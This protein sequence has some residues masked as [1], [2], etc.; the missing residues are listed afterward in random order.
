MF[1]R[2]LVWTKRIFTPFALG[3]LLYATWQSRA[4]LVMLFTTAQRQN[5]II[6]LPLLML[7]HLI[8]PLA[9][10]VGLKSLGISVP[11]HFTLSTHIHRLPA[12]Y[13]PGGIWHSVGRMMDFHAYGIHPTQLTIFFVLENILSISVSFILGGLGVGYFRGGSDQWGMLGFL[14]SL[15]NIVILVAIP[16]VFIRFSKMI[17]RHYLQAISCYIFLIFPLFALAFVCYLSAFQ[18]GRS[19][20]ETGS[21]YLFSWA[22]G[23]V[24][25][26]APQGLGVFEVMVGHLLGS[27]LSLHNFVALIVG[28]RVFSMVADILLWGIFSTYRILRYFFRAHRGT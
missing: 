28:F 7:P 19:G 8:S 10:V 24:T 1:P 14:A 23:L 6:T 12:R 2:I 25:F 3:A 21:I 26:F 15:G 20:L 11:Y 22:V 9:V 13:L 17:L 5:L 4:F 16:I 27:S 18:L